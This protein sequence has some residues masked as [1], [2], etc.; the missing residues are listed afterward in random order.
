[1]WAD[2][3]QDS[4]IKYNSQRLN[5]AYDFFIKIEIASQHKKFKKSPKNNNY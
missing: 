3:R 5:I 4:H 1:M 2:R